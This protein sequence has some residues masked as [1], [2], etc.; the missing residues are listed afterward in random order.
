MVS[1]DKCLAHIV[2]YYRLMVSTY[3]SLVQTDR[4]TYR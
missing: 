2:S 3:R 1:T 4:S